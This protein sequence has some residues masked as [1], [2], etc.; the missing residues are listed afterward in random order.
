MAFAAA[1]ACSTN[2]LVL[3]LTTPQDQPLTDENS[4]KLNFISSNGPHPLVGMGVVEE[5]LTHHFGKAFHID[6]FK[7]VCIEGGRSS[8]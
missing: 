4:A 7:V 1:Q 2:S 3:N 6:N 8:F 5:M